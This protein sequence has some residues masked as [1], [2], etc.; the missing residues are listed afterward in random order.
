MHE[1]CPGGKF[2]LSCLLRLS[3]LNHDRRWKRSCH[4]QH[5]LLLKVQPKFQIHVASPTA[6]KRALASSFYRTDRFSGPCRLV[7]RLFYRM[8]ILTQMY[9]VKF[10]G[11]NL[12]LDEETSRRRVFAL[13]SLYSDPSGCFSLPVRRSKLLISSALKKSRCS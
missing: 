6:R 12:V 10:P 2:A 4:L 11:T 13:I 8:S 5:Q 1:L 3:S 7:R 9:L